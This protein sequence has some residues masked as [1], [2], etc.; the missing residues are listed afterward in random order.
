MQPLSNITFT[1]TMLAPLN[2]T[3]DYGAEGEAVLKYVGFGDSVTIVSKT[4]VACTGCSLV[5]LTAQVRPFHMS[6][7]YLLAPLEESP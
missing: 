6:F 5:N 7:L 4:A 2:N 3:D 1:V